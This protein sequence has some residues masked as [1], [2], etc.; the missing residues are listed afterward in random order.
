[1][2]GK[3]PSAN[4]GMF[5]IF[6]EL[7]SKSE[8]DCKQYVHYIPFKHSDLERNQCCA[9]APSSCEEQRAATVWRLGPEVFLSEAPSGNSA[10]LLTGAPGENPQGRGVNRP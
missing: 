3:Q 6:T 8:R 4:F 1:M 2:T 5:L 7:Q 9:P 10:R